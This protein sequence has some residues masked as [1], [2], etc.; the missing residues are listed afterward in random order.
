MKIMHICQFLGVGGLEKVLYSL[1]KEQ[2]ILGHQVEVVVYD[3]DRSWVEKYRN[4]GITV[5]TDYDKN[6]GYDF[7]LLSYLKLKISGFDIIH[8]HDLNPILYVGVI[9]FFNS[10]INLIHTT[11]GMEHLDTHPKTRLYEIFL[12]VIADCIIAVAPKFQQYYQTQFLTNK[13]KVHIIS[14]GT[15]ITASNIITPIKNIRKDVFKEFSLDP[16]VPTGIYVARVVP[17]KAQDKIIKVYRASSH[18][19]IIVGPSGNDE[20]YNQCK[21]NISTNIKMTG[22]RD[23]ITRLLQSCDYYIS[24]SLHEGLPIAVLEAGAQALPCILNNIPGHV[25][26]NTENKCVLIYNNE[27]D[28]KI[29]LDE[30]LIK[31]ETLV[32]QFIKLIKDKYSSHA[33]ARAY[34]SFYEQVR[35]S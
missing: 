15:E 11:H 8:T 21:E 23:D 25:T 35:K 17:L 18:Q 32:K 5:H 9:K 30:I 34:I 13:N 10:K 24:P 26:F 22:S 31:K 33:M 14:N 29:K 1:I 12:G 16:S 4:L 19:L 28:L 2:L 7:N 20:Y 27:N 3:H 6:P